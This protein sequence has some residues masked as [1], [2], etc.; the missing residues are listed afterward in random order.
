VV[1]LQVSGPAAGS[2]QL[3]V[4]RGGV[5][6]PGDVG[7]IFDDLPPIATVIGTPVDGLFLGIVGPQ[8][9]VIVNPSAPAGDYVYN[10]RLMACG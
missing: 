4:Y 9:S 5:I 6:A 1:V 7:A 10:V 3:R 2:F 8:A